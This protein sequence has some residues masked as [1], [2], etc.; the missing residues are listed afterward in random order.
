MLASGEEKTLGQKMED[1]YL[2]F[3]NLY[4]CYSLNYVHTYLIKMN[5]FKGK[6]SWSR[7]LLLSSERCLLSLT[8]L[9]GEM[10][11]VITKG[12]VLVSGTLIPP[13]TFP[14]LQ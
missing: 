13:A 4:N 14:H 9:N 5:F 11:I 12:R 6:T 3:K 7:M 2:I 8:T 10:S 1:C